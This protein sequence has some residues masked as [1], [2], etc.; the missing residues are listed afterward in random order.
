MRFVQY[1]LDHRR[2]LILVKYQLRG[3]NFLVIFYNVC[4]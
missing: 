4:M 3:Y 2:N 1:L